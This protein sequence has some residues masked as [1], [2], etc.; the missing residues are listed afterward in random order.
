MTFFE[1]LGWGIQKHF[2]LRWI[3]RKIKAGGK[4]DKAIIF[5]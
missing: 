3:G 1:N 2:E 4:D 5:R